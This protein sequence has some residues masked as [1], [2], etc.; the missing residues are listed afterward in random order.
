MLVG[1]VGGLAAVLAGSHVLHDLGDLGGGDGDGLR[2]GHRGVAQREAVGQHVPE[3]RQRA[4]GLR[5]ERRVIG[6]VEVDVALHMRVRHRRRQHGERGGLGHGA[7]QQIAL[8]G[9][10]V[11]VLV[12][13]LVN[14]GRILID[15][16]GHG[17]IDI[18]GLGALDVAVQT[19]AG[20]GAGHVIQVVL[21][22]PVLDEVLDVL[23]LG[24]TGVA[25]LDL[26]LD[27]IGDAADQILLLRA[28]LL[29]QIG[30]RGLDGV[31]D[32]GRVEIHDTTVTLLH[33]HGGG[34]GARCFHHPGLHGRSLLYGL[35][36]R[37]ITRMKF[38]QLT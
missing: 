10:D 13:V 28:H 3:V 29:V 35:R 5:G 15:E 2:A 16:A 24:G 14:Q 38:F 11:G 26:A 31:D 17:L 36:C 27:L 6:V 23:D 37:Q 21:D 20:V 33:Q 34:G 19:V 25:Q 1:A 4:V 30:E 18:G 32:V 12:R 22:Q 9:V 8:G 7:G